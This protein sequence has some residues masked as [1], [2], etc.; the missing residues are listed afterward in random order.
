M[1]RN[2]LEPGKDC[3]PIE[4]L[5]RFVDPGMVPPEIGGHLESC[6]YCR[7]ELELLRAYLRE[8]SA[9][10]AEAV[11][12]VAE[13]LRLPRPARAAASGAW[14]RTIFRHG[15]VRPAALAM[16]GI[17]IALAIGIQLQHSSAPRLYTGGSEPEI[18]RSGSISVTSPVGDVAEVPK[19]IH[20]QAVPGADHYQVRLLEVDQTQLWNSSTQ[21]S[22]IELPAGIQ[23]RILPAKTLLL[24]VTAFDSTGHKLAESQ[25]TRFRFLQKVYPR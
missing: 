19:R 7:T 5:E 9:E 3:L 22:Q 15:W 25:T 24:Q 16:A 17:L 13:R 11:R 10:E 12:A 1:L 8:P 23:G 20:W 18:M 6:A 4:A 14:W 2:A 21:E